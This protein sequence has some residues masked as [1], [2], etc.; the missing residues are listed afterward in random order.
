VISV[1]VYAEHP[2]LALVPT[3]REVPDVQMTVLPDAATDP[4]HEIQFITIDAPDFGAV[5]SALAADPTVDSYSRVMKQDDR[6]TY[7]IEYTDEAKTVSPAITR[8][9]GL[10]VEATNEARGWRLTL[11]L[12]DRE[13]LYE[14]RDGVEEQGIEFEVLGIEEL[15]STRE[16]PDFG[17]TEPQREA[18]VA[19]FV[20]GYYDE[21][22]EISLEKLAESL[23]IS[24]TAVSGRLRRG[25]ARLIDEFLIED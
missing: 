25:S 9:T 16:E 14:L 10:V 17:L 20:N 5:E 22:R 23:D 12:Q 18:L 7:A 8:A 6:W 1:Q 19:A 24:P 15:E 11:K 3:I 2:S 21:P 13:E 4:Q